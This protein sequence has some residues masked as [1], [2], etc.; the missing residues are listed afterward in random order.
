M[1]EMTDLDGHES[2]QKGLGHPGEHVPP[3][4]GLLTPGQHVGGGQSHQRDAVGQE[5]AVPDR[6]LADRV[7]EDIG[8]EQQADADEGRENAGH[9]A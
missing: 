2:D 8:I 6:C 4:P 5:Q 1:K 7:A 9:L 3:T